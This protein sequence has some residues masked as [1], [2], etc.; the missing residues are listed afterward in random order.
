MVYYLKW[1]KNKGDKMANG[2]N[3]TPGRT[4][5][6]D[7]SK[8]E[9]FLHYLDIRMKSLE[10]ALNNIGNLSNQ[11]VYK[12]TEEQ[13]RTTLSTINKWHSEMRQRW[14]KEQKKQERKE[15]FSQM[16]KWR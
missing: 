9:K 6:K 12:Y 15:T 8:S 4:E 14:S 7:M 1:T 5:T 10:T 2:K 16:H 13:K 3:K 11:N